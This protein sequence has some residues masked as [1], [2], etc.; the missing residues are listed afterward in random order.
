[1]VSESI[2]GA[3]TCVGLSYLLCGNCESCATFSRHLQSISDRVKR[4]EHSSTGADIA[5]A[6]TWHTPCQQIVSQGPQIWDA[7]YSRMVALVTKHAVGSGSDG[8]QL[9]CRIISL[10]NKP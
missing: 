10:A 1:M 6:C 2:S 5:I 4:L 9:R 8:L 3:V 7:P